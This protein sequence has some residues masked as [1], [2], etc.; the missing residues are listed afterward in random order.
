MAV[1]VSPGK[2]IWAR[3]QLFLVLLVHP[4]PGLPAAPARGAGCVAS[5][6]LI[7]LADPPPLEWLTPAFST[8][9]AP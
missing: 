5:A 2:R 9:L 3:C 7:H 1:Q 4:A 6:Q 8:R